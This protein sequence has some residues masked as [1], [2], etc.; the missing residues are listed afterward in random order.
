MIIPLLILHGFVTVAMIGLILLQKSDEAGPL[1]MGGGGGNNSLFTARGVANIL[2][3]TTGILATL[4]FGNCLLIGILTQKELSANRLFAEEAKALEANKKK[5][6]KAENKPAEAPADTKATETSTRTETQP[7]ASEDDVAKVEDQSLAE[8]SIEPTLETIENEAETDA[9]AVEAML[10]SSDSKAEEVGKT[11]ENSEKVDE[12][13]ENGE[14]S[15]T[16]AETEPGKEAETEKAEAT[17]ESAS[18]E[19]TSVEG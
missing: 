13:S 14:K 4:F 7:E 11:P 19:S 17:S 5:A 1:G 12:T 6:K 2:T 10:G 15:E 18:G 9:K 8:A 16:A 3:R